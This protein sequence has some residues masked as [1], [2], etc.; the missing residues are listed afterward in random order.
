MVCGIEQPLWIKG[1]SVRRPLS[2]L[3]REISVHPRDGCEGLGLG[4]A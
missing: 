3:F 1:E 4:R 2:I